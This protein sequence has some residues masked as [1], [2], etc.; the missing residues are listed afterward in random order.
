MRALA[1]ACVL[2]GVS[3]CSLKTMAVKTVANTLSENGDVFSRDDDPE[4]VREAVPFALKLYESL[5]DSVPDHAPLLLATCSAFT[6]YAFAF[7]ETDAEVAGQARYEETKALKARALKLYLRGR[8]Y[9]LRGMEVRFPGSSQGLLSNPDAVLAKARKT[10][11]PL[12]YWAAASWGAAISLGIDQPDLV[13]DFPTVRTLAERALALD[14]TWNK[15]ALHELMISL[16][17]LPDALGGNVERARTHFTRAVE[18]QQGASPGPYV[19]LATGV[20]VPAQ[21]R[22]EFERLLQQALAVDP[23]KD[24]SNRLSTLVTQRRARAL[25]EQI[26]SRFAN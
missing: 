8:G 22:A 16:D 6:Q 7:V 17:S 3:A 5:L 24:P 9:C 14:E 21:D 2:V 10:D 15:G 1:F 12:L 19:A 11:V 18:L 23:E 25:L 20:A 26:D 4:L 13:I